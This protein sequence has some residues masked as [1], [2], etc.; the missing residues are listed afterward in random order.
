MNAYKYRGLLETKERYGEF[1]YSV[2][3]VFDGRNFS[4][5]IVDR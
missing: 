1:K 4:W 5:E 2:D 3:V